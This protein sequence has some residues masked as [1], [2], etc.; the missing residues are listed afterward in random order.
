MANKGR[1]DDD[2]AFFH[3]DAAKIRENFARFRETFPNVDIAFGRLKKCIQITPDLASR[4]CTN[5]TG[6]V[7]LFQTFPATRIRSFSGLSSP[8]SKPRD[9]TTKPVWAACPWFATIKKNWNGPRKFWMNERL[10]RIW[11][12]FWGRARPSICPWSQVRTRIWFSSEWPDIVN[13]VLVW[14]I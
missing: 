3:F 11:R 4:I 13:F 14:I 5:H 7:S 8:D 6:S 12:S 9:W 1:N 2:S 10:G